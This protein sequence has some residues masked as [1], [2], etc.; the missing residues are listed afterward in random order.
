MMITASVL[1]EIQTEHTPITRLR[2]LGSITSH[3]YVFTTKINK[4]LCP[5]VSEP[6]DQNIWEVEVQLHAPAALSLCKSSRYPSCRIL[7]GP[8]SHSSR[9]GE[10]NLSL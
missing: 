8:D 7:S 3:P 9:D 1:A 2:M 5:Y 4:Q 10:K 6:G